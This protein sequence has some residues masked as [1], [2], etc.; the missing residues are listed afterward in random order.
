LVFWYGI[1]VLEYDTTLCFVC[2]CN[3][4]EVIFFSLLTQRCVHTAV[5]DSMF[6]PSGLAI[7]RSV[8]C[9]EHA[10]ELELCTIC[11]LF[12]LLPEISF[13]LCCDIMYI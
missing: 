3:S 1:V 8:T 9:S 12:H 7:I 2:Y 13:P 4:T 10:D 6:H 11:I 5:S